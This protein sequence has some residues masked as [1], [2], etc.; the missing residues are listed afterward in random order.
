MKHTPEAIEAQSAELR[1][2]LVSVGADIRHH[3]DPSVVV[4]A[5]KESFKRRVE[6]APAFL[7]V[8][9]EFLLPDP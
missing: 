4:D 6:E 5:A 2:Q 1:A 8:C 3:A 9:D 7:C